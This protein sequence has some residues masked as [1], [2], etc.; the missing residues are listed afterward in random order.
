MKTRANKHHFTLGTAL[1]SLMLAVA[2]PVAAHVVLDQ[3]TAP[4][5]STYKAALR[6]SHGCEGAPTTGVVVQIPAGFQGAKPQPKAGWTL[7]VRREKLAK[8]YQSHGKTVTEDVVEIRWTAASREAALPDGQFDEFVLIGRLPDA[9]GSLWFKV[10]QPCESGQNDWSQVPATGTST[11]GLKS[12][13][14]LLEVMPA[15][16]EHGAH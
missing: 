7:A 13:A 11:R 14:V 15:A 2:G 8:P 10:L 4:A 5:G 9:A 12:P 3:P 6:V 16:H 1:F